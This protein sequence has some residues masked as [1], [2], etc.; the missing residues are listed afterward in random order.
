MISAIIF[1]Y[2][3]EVNLP[4]CLKSLQNCSDIVVVDSF[5]TDQTCEIARKHGARVYQNRFTGL[6][7]QRMWAI[8][9]IHFQNPWALILDADERVTPELWLEM[10]QQTSLCSSETAAFQLKRR[11]YWEGEWIRYANLY[12]S[13]VVRLIRVGRVKYLNRGHAETQEVEGRILSLKA[14][15]IDENHKGLAAWH[16]RQKKYALQEAEYE[17]ASERVLFSDVWSPDPLKRRAAIKGAA[18]YFPFRGLIYFVYV[19][20]FRLGFL[21]GVVGFKFC[22]EKARYQNLIGVLARDLKRS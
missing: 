16:E 17:I 6:G 15:L 11:F 20:F 14:D 12:P 3:E 13:W 10:I 1:T 21:D 9:H 2:N 7:D 19:Y 5:S 18:R 4:Y 8:N 22:L